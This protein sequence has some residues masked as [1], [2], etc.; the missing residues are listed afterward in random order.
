MVRLLWG[1][2]DLQRWELV[3]VGV[4]LYTAIQ[5]LPQRS[6]GRLA[7]LGPCGTKRHGPEAYAPGAMHGLE[8][9]GFD[10]PGES[11]QH[12]YG[13]GLAP[14]PNATQMRRKFP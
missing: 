8:A 9:C 1:L 6:S 10:G 13:G 2:L 12:I 3:S 11:L 7:L 14:P 5:R 4:L